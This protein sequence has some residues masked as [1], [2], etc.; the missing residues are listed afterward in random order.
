[1]LGISRRVQIFLPI[2]Q[3]C[4]S[5]MKLLLKLA[6]GP[7]RDHQGFSE[8]V[9]SIHAAKSTRAHN[10]PIPDA[11]G[12]NASL[13]DCLDK[14]TTS[15]LGR[16]AV[17]AFYYLIE[18]KRGT[19]RSEFSERPM[20]VLEEMRGILGAGFHVL[21]GAITNQIRETY[22]VSESDLGLSKTIEAARRNYLK[23]FS[24]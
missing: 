3:S 6:K 4:I 20:E 18:Q 1:M 5:R 7:R 2:L 11:K 17:D 22:K 14:V 15:M 24:R 12:F 16:E 8:R 23:Y 21:E 13:F 19:P 10:T 9:L